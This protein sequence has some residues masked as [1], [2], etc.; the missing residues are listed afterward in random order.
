MSLLLTPHSVDCRYGVVQQ[1]QHQTVIVVAEV[2]PDA[3]SSSGG[4]AQQQ[5]Q[6]A[7]TSSTAAGASPLDNSLAVV[8]LVVTSPAVDFHVTAATASPNGHQ[9]L[10]AGIAQQVSRVSP[11]LSR[12]ALQH[13]RQA[14]APTS[15]NDLPLRSPR[16][17]VC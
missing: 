16:L 3:L 9:L 17:F 11:C 7:A 6:D 13:G 12:I 4:T 10:L 2:S 1:Q 5:R 8:Q 14:A 15:S